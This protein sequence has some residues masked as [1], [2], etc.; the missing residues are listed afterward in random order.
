MIFGSIPTSIAELYKLFF[1][2]LDK[3]ISFLFNSKTIFETSNIS[4]FRFTSTE[5]TASIG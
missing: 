1:I 2:V 4:L 3:T 5:V